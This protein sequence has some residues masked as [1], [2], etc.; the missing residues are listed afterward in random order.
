MS[1]KYDVI[2]YDLYG[3]GNRLWNLEFEKKNECSC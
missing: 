1:H 2:H 3:V